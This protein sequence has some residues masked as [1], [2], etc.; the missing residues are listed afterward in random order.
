MDERDRL[1]SREYIA[2]RGRRRPAHAVRNDAA[3]REAAIALIADVGWDEFSLSKASGATGVAKSSVQKR[4]D[5]KAGLAAEAWERDLY[6]ALTDA[7]GHALATGLPPAAPAPE[8]GAPAPPGAVPAS[9]G[10]SGLEPAADFIDAMTAFARPA[11]GIRAAVELVLASLVDPALTGPVLEPTRQWLRDHVTG[12]PDPVRAA[13]GT[14]I[15]TWAL[16][17]TVFSTR[18]WTATMDLAPALAHAHRALAHPTAPVALPDAVAAHLYD[19]PFNT[20]DPR[21]DLAL[22]NALAS[23]GTIGYHRTRLVDIATKTGV[24]EGFILI[25]FTTKLGLMRAIIDAGYAEGYQAFIDYQE[26]IAAEHGPGI[27]E[28]TA[29]RQYLD[30][31]ISDRQTLGMETDRLS[32]FNPTMRDTTFPQDLAV[33]NQQLAGTPDTDRNTATGRIHLDFASGHGLPITAL[34]LPE[35]W[36]L[37]FNTITEPYLQQLSVADTPT[38]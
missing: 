4:Y 13:Q 36:T 31:R 19:S 3:L 16:G 10:P 2:A 34:L 24:S 33:L 5:G 27:A 35:A 15:L 1:A 25:R 38:P 22:D 32:L 17:L 21:I 11:P 6:P 37:P 26:R 7:I 18:P 23:I 14:A 29:W 8:P 12:T 9:G 20:D 28:A 30:P